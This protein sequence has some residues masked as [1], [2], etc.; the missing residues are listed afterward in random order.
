MAL[1]MDVE[2]VVKDET[3]FSFAGQALVSAA[4]THIEMFKLR[5]EWELRRLRGEAVMK[6]P[7]VPSNIARILGSLPIRH[8]HVVRRTLVHLSSATVSAAVAW[9]CLSCLVNLVRFPPL[10]DGCSTEAQP[11]HVLRGETR[12]RRDSTGD[13]GVQQHT[14]QGRVRCLVPVDSHVCTGAARTIV[15]QKQAFHGGMQGRHGTTVVAG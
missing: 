10:G 11:R 6:K 5:E 14:K 15:G 4:K 8:L 2:E 9:A 12:A 3:L 13:A 1:Q 7:K